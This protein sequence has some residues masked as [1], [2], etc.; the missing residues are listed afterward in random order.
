[1]MIVLWHRSK[2]RDDIQARWTVLAYL[3]AGSPGELAQAPD[4]CGRCVVGHL[5]PAAP[6][7]LA[8]SGGAVMGREE[9]G[10][11]AGGPQGNLWPTGWRPNPPESKKS[12]RQR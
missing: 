10:K 8:L 12:A 2:W 6:L 11:S 7:R 5:H 1:M 4:R 9:V 3:V